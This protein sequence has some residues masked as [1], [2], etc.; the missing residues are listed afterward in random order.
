MLVGLADLG[1]EVD[2]VGVGIS[3]RLGEGRQRNNRQCEGDDEKNSGEDGRAAGLQ[4]HL[5]PE[6]VRN[7]LELGARTEVK[8]RQDGGA[9]RL[10]DG[11]H[12]KLYPCAARDC[13]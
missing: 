13:L 2:G 5:L 1:G 9:L 7:G 4:N 11:C 12:R 3:D 8:F 10:L 6:G